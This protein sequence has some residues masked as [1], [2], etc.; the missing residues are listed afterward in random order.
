VTFGSHRKEFNSPKRERREKNTPPY[1]NGRMERDP[2][3]DRAVFLCRA[4][5]DEEREVN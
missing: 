5:Y 3:E 2:T 1:E 4:R